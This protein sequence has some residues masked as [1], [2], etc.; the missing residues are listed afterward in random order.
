MGSLSLLQ[1]IFPTRGSSPGLPH[2]RRI[3]YQLSH[4]G[5]LSQRRGTI[6]QQLGTALRGRPRRPLHQL[7]AGSTGLCYI[8]SWGW[9]NLRIGTWLQSSCLPKVGEGNTTKWASPLCSCHRARPSE[10]V[11]VSL[12]V[13]AEAAE[14]S[15]GIS[16]LSLYSLFSVPVVFLINT[17][18]IFMKATSMKQHNITLK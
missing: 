7:S 14:T 18:E 10:G 1:G 2:C 11:D 13:V 8:T 16:S 4:K 12:M 15:Q 3:L 6:V 17:F 5:S 9:F